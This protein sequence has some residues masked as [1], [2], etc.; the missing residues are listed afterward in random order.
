M[1]SMSILKVICVVVRNVFV[2]RSI[3]VAENSA[4][5]EQLAVQVRTIKQPKLR[6]S[7]VAHFVS[8]AKKLQIS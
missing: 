1:K 6:K 3:L 2:N 7:V 4:L 8:K 5:R